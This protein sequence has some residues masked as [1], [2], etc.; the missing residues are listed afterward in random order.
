MNFLRLPIERPVTTVMIFVGVA[1]LGFIS[2]TRIPNELF[3]SLEYPQIT[4]V[5]KYEGAGPEEA[6]KLISR[7]VEETVGTVKNVKK[8][9]S[10]SKEGVSIVSCEF[11]WGTNMDLAAMD[12]REKIDLIKESLPRDSQDPI[13][14]KYNPLQVEAMTL[15]VDYKSD[16]SPDPLKMAE[17]RQ[18]CKKNLKDELERLDGV[19]KVEIRGGEKKE[20]L[21]EIDKGRLLANQVSIV[22]VISSLRDANITY[23]AGTIKEDNFEYLVKTVGEFQ[24]INDIAALSFGKKDE[25]TAQRSSSRRIRNEGP[26]RNDKIVFLRDIG[27]I[28][29]SLKDKTGYSRYYHY[30]EKD[31]TSQARVIENISL[32]IYPQSGSNLIKMSKAVNGRL[33]ELRER[34]PHDV[35]VKV[36]YDQS[37]FV[38]DSLKNI[39]QNALQGMALSFI[40]LFIFMKSMMASVIINIAIPIT[41]LITLTLMYFCDIS[42]NTMSLSG[43]TV[44]IGMV[45]DNSNVV[46]ENILVNY[47]KNPEKDKKEIIYESTT[48]LL[49]AIISS[50]LT[51]VSIFL[52]FIFVTGMSGQ[53]FKQ[54]ALTITFSMIASIF[55]AIF[56]VPRMALSANLAKQSINVGKAS[57]EK[58][59]VPA[60]RRVLQWP[61]K[62]M[63]FYTFIYFLAGF[64][65]YLFIPKEFMPKVDERRFVLNIT[66]HPETPLAKTNEVTKRI[67]NL[68]VKYPEIKDMGI[69]VGSTGDSLGAAAVESLGAYQARIVAR[70]NDKGVSTNEIVTQVNDD[71]RKWNIKNL[72]TEFIT[73]QGLF[74]SNIGAGSGLVIEVKGKDLAKL[75]ERSE[76]IKRM[77]GD[78]PGFYGIRIS[79]SDLVPELKVQ[80]D[81]ERASMFGLSTQDISAM[82][83]AGI[84]GYVATKLKL[85]DDEFDVRVRMR[86]E[87]RDNIGKV[88]E[89]T[90]YS[91]WGMTIQMKQVSQAVFV[92]SL[93][94]IKRSEGQRTYLVTSN[95]KGSFSKAV[96]ELRSALKDLPAKG[97]ITTNIG[98]EMLAMR[99]SMKSSVFAMLLGIIIIYMI[100]ASQFESLSQPLIVMTAV[101]L[102]L[103]GAILALFCTF[104]SINSISLLGMI[105]LIG[106]VVSISIILVDRYN[107]SLSKEPDADLEQVVVRCTADHMRPI[108]MTTLTTIID[109]FPLALGLGKGAESTAPMAIAVVG[110]LSFALVMTLF[111]VPFVYMV[112][113][114]HKR[115]SEE[116]AGFS[117]KT[118]EIE[119]A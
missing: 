109:L 99:E 63:L 102:G 32:G 1:L 101:P 28:K 6:E 42:I 69:T 18:F 27:D 119:E 25:S 61:V 103:I 13:V 115:L 98:G 53:L 106:N 31:P 4:I 86:P 90:A 46:L 66:M 35:E 17:L 114:G 118:V 113:K 105:M 93:P 39:Y 89:M 72:E 34:L 48:E 73:Q 14:L 108:M 91:P 67:E 78:M 38:D 58:Y 41:M 100:L 107:F 8:V 68:L 29:E 21:V 70:L 76:E 30:D 47:H 51:T 88:I 116:G 81:R 92:K 40:L 15:S 9:S 56:L 84:K 87:D 49:G 44:G 62:R 96:G 111:F 19:A 64:L 26:Q 94:E 80:V 83:L 24:S 75:R 60:L 59:F 33:K 52:P 79:P 10:V 71:I 45:V 7:I 37:E 65:I 74:G 112:A 36:I 54:L 22:E 16:R 11:R 43:L 55:V 20:I 50:T 23:P 2:W 82:T 57:T 3:P 97:D 5:T 117:P 85:K 110:G 77:M 95:V 12:V 104:K